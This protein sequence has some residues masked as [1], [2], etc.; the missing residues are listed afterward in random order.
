MM[1]KILVMVLTFVFVFHF[2]GATVLANEAV[3]VKSGTVI[4]VSVKSV[5][6]S[7][8]VKSGDKIECLIAQD[9][10]I[11][12]IVVFKKGGRATLNVSGAKK[13][14]L[15]AFRVNSLSQAV[16]STT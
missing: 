2:T 6:N 8:T 5:Q 7:K 16:K 1:K 11:N 3:T 12:D 9:I 15:S 14:V 4:P 10:V 13:P